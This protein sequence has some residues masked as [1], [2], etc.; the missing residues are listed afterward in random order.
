MIQVCVHDLCLVYH[1]CHADVEC[2]DFKDFL[3][4]NLVKFVTI[5]FGN[6]KE[7]LG[8]IGLVVGNPLDLQKNR[9]VPSCQ[10]SMLTLAGAMVHPPYGKLVKP[11]YMFHR[12]ACQWNVLDIDHIQYAAMDGYLY[13]NIYKGWMKSNSQVCGSSKEVSAKRKR[14]KDEVED[15]DENS[16]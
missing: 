13:F 10:P 6:D 16:E 11:P 15:V 8:R 14:D 3:G 7:I 4:S 9:L 1:I 12:H 2:Q 5:D